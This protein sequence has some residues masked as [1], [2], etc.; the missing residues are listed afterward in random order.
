VNRFYSLFYRVNKSGD[1][2]VS[3]IEFMN[4]FDLDRT[5][6]VSKAFDYCDTVGGGEMDFLEFVVSVANFCMLK[7]NTLTDFTFDLYD[8]D[9]DG[10]ISYDELVTM[11][12]ELYG[13]AWDTSSL[14]RECL[15]ELALLSEKFGGGIPLEGFVK[16]QKTHQTLLFPAFIIQR[17]VQEKVFGVSYWMGKS[18]EDPARAIKHGEKRFDPR[19]VQTILRT[20]KTGSAA[21]IL[22]HT[23]DPNEGLR[24]WIAKGKN[25]ELV[26]PAKIREEIAQ[27]RQ[28]KLALIAEW[29][30]RVNPKMREDYR[31]QLLAEAKVGQDIK[32]REMVS[33]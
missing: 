33:V 10:E 11:V 4:F 14:A 25:P 24:D 1:G 29:R 9:G 31:Q 12:K 13:A 3:I 8:L 7:P 28:A 2:E 30:R 16:F 26:D 18:N 5:E 19:H 22:T 20:Y 32:K 15:K 21:A 23:G 27:K 6:Y 17:T